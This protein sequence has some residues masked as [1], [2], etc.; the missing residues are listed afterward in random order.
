MILHIKYFEG[1][2]TPEK[3]PV[4]LG[5]KNLLKIAL[6]QVRI[7]LYVLRNGYLTTDNEIN[8]GYNYNCYF[9]FF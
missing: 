9:Y 1:C 2:M 3:V 7:N 8:G 4:V 6:N 5:T